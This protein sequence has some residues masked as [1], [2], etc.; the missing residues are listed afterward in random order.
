[1][2]IKNG[3]NRIVITMPR[4]GIVIKLPIINLFSAIGTFYDLFKTCL[5]VKNRSAGKILLKIFLTG[6]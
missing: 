4:L 2:I 3:R 6:R 1:M 5:S